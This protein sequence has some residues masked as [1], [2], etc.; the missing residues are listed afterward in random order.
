MSQGRPSS[1]NAG[2][3]LGPYEIQQPVGAGGMGEVYRA[4]D[5]R[6]DRTVA[7]KVS[8]RQFSDRFHREAQAIA[9]LNHP[10]ICTLH[11]VGPDY[12]VMEFIEGKPIKGPLPV[13]EAVRLAMQIADALVHAHRHGVVHRDLKPANILVT[14]QGVKV[15]DF[16]L[17]KL[18]R[19][20]QASSDDTMAATLT[21]EGTILGTPQ[22]MAPEQM[23]GKEADVR[24]D[25]FA[26]GLVLYEMLTGRPA[27]DGKTKASLIA[28]I[29]GAEPAPVTDFQ[30]LV[31]PALEHVIRT[32]LAKDPDERR[33]TVHDVLLELRWIAAGGTQAGI[34]KP[35]VERKRGRERLSWV[36]V[37]ALSVALMAVGAVHFRERPPNVSP[38]YFEIPVPAS[39]DVFDVAISPDGKQ[40]AFVTSGAARRMLW[41]RPLDSPGARMLPG[42]EDAYSIAWSPDSRSIAFTAYGKLKRTDLAGDAPLVLCDAT[43]AGDWSHDGTILFRSPAGNLSRISASGGEPQAVLE[44]DQAR[45]E[46]I[47]VAPAF[48]PDG[49]RF[50]YYSVSERAPGI[51]AGSLDSKQVRFVANLPPS[52]ISPVPPGFL[53][54]PRQQTLMAQPFDFDKL[55]ARGDPFPVL[56]GIQTRGSY[57]LFSSSDNGVLVTRGVGSGVVRQVTRYDRAGRAIGTAGPARSYVKIEISPDDRWA[58]MDLQDNRSSDVWLLNL[59]SGIL[60]LVT[61]APG[62]DGEPTWSPDGREILFSSRKNRR[63]EIYRMA[64]GGKEDRSVFTAPTPA[65]VE[66]WLPDGS[67]LYIDDGGRS[68]YRLPLSGEA[69]PELLLKTEYLKDEPSVSADGRW[70]A[71]STDE[72]GQWE[73]Y[74]ASFPSLTGKRQISVNGGMQPKWRKDGRELFYAG[75]DGSIFSVEIRQ[76]DPIEF[77]APEVLFRSHL[78]PDPRRDEYAVTGDGKQLLILDPVKQDSPPLRVLLNWQAAIQ[79]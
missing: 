43:E 62:A 9:S 14:K 24:T 55:E 25:I 50:F 49:R 66:Q 30:P 36:L 68:F 71:Y 61:S 73:I 44:L 48:L 4:R 12:L 63:N 64:I 79:R 78:L 7:I 75:P 38:V 42:T 5:T 33:Q 41:I 6:L 26:F 60:S 54:F 69:K 32:C 76:G 70:I 28:A 19:L 16:G 74:A 35:M 13:D 27:F 59:T 72:T 39:T 8:G 56:T 52:A 11:D 65:F 21:Q 23:E 2:A 53:L 40:L 18:S 57:M 10:N 3:R 15:L 20:P 37:G 58:L 17:A 47:Q 31:P 51:Y 22:Y 77:G 29:M 1:L 46:R 45:G 67:A 34:P